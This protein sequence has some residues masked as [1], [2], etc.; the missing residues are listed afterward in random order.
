MS[1]T[2]YSVSAPAGSGKTHALVGHAIDL[3]K[4]NQKIIIAQPSEVLIKQTEKDIKARPGNVRLNKILWNTVGSNQSVINAILNF[5]K[6][7]HEERPAEGEILLISQQALSRLPRAYRQFWHLVVDEV[8]GA[9]KTHE[10]TIAESHGYITKHLTLGEALI[11]DNMVVEAA[12]VNGLRLLSANKKRDSA[13]ALFKELADDVLNPDKL[14]IVNADAYAKLVAN[15]GTRD[16]VNFYAFHKSEFV[17]DF[18]STTVMGANFED[19]ELAKLWEKL[20]NIEWKPHPVISKNLRYTEHQNG[21]RLTIK[22]V[23]HGNWSQYY[24]SRP[25]ADGNIL[26]AVVD[27]MSNELQQD[28]LWQANKQHDDLFDE[29]DKLP[30]IVHG[31]NRKSYQSKHGVALVKAIN[32]SSGTAAF[33]KD[34]GLSAEELKVTLQ[35]QNEYQAMMRCS[36]RDPNATAPVTVCVVSEGS[37]RWLENLFPNCKVEKLNTDIP[38][39]KPIGQPSPRPKSTA[40]RAHDSRQNKKVREAAARGE[41]YVARPWTPRKVKF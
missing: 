30:Q 28:F 24:A 32:H 19:T 2:F 4:N 34:I 20:D 31:L 25:F 11:G 36:L 15:E 1:Q 23:I 16:C 29:G 8:P 7:S 37:A 14:V 41:V 5:L 3:A 18:A 17:M 9:F 21:I 26:A 35:Y 22:Y 27:A 33:L 39:P 10:M 6:T 12:D 38:E 13:F 40:E